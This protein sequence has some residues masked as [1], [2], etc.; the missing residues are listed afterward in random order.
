M[1]N[2]LKP[3]FEKQERDNKTDAFRAD[4]MEGVAGVQEQVANAS[5]ASLHLNKKTIDKMTSISTQIN[6]M[7]MAVGTLIEQGKNEKMSA[8]VSRIP[9]K[10]D[11]LKHQLMEIHGNV[12][13]I[14]D[15]LK[16]SE[17]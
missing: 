16:S 13:S 1:S 7:V 2:A 3:D 10:V 17:Q 6:D 8:E 4:L 15:V 11:E 12:T 5:D 14:L 9:P